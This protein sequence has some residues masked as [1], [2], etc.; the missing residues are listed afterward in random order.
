[1][2][3]VQVKYK[4]LRDLAVVPSY[5]TEHAAGMDLFSANDEPI[6]I[7]VGEIAM[8]PLGFAMALPDHYEAQVRPRSGLGS[9]FGIS[10][11][12]SPG[13]IDADYR[14][15]LSVP[16]INHGKVPFV[17]ETNMRIA[18]MI[19]APVVQA[20]FEVVEELDETVRGAG[21]FGSTGN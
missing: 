7:D 21:G 3:L 6:T 15:E 5:Q 4:K 1:M 8:I 20:S 11:P 10:L 2:H 12:N 13:T 19:I 18:Q 14:G 17:V 16:L 9:K